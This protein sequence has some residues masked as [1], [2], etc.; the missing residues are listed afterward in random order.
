MV[1]PVPAE[2]FLL[3]RSRRRLTGKSGHGSAENRIG[4][5]KRVGEEVVAVGGPTLV[6][7]GIIL[8]SK[9]Q[10]LFFCVTDE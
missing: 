2:S 5:L 1:V 3:S 4:E 9:L 10:N 8:E 6:S 7:L